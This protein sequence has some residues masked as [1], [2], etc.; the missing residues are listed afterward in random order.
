MPSRTL[1]VG[2]AEIT[3]ILDV[4]TSIPLIAF[5]D[6]SGDPAPDGFASLAATYPDEFTV[7]TWRF[8]ARCFVVRTPGRLTLIDAGVGPADSAFGRWLGVTGT[9]ADEL[10]ALGIAPSEVDDVILTHMH[11]D[12]TGWSTEVAPSGWVPR[13]TNA[14]YHLHGADV[15]AMRSSVGEDERR[16]FAEVIA[17]LEAADQ[18]DPSTQDRA[19]SPGL[20][21]RHAPGHTPGHRCVLLDTGDERVLFTG[22]L[23][24]FTFELNDP[25]FRAPGEHD[26]DAASRTRAMWLDRAEDEGLTVAT[27]HVPPAPIARIVRHNGERRLEPR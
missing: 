19:V 18:L 24:H 22:D 25:S 21:L 27:A 8:H 20:E 11:S 4:M 2:N 14:R 17:P 12:H 6:G 26:P 9:L 16:E 15:E 3:P 13:F 10:A 1:A 23:L 7:D 5:F